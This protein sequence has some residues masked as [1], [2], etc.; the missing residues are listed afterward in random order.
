MTC[1][2][3]LHPPLFSIFPLAISLL[4]PCFAP[5]PTRIWSG[6]WRRRHGGGGRSSAPSGSGQRGAAARCGTTGA[7]GSAAAAGACRTTTAAG[8]GDC[9][10]CEE[11]VSPAAASLGGA[12]LRNPL[13]APLLRRLGA[14]A[15]ALAI[16]AVTTAAANAGDGESLLGFCCCQILNRYLDLAITSPSRA[17]ISS[18]L[19]YRDTMRC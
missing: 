5:T 16:P 18:A 19:P 11:R 9:H 12:Q 8:V 4:P 10:P 6:I 2:P 14:L 15:T 13:L 1:P 7:A 3:A 17:P